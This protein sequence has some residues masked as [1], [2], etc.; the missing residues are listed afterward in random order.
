MSLAYKQPAQYKRSAALF[1]AARSIIPGGVNSTA[2]AIWSGWE[3]YPLFVEKGDGAYLTD[4]D[5][6]T[7]IDYLLGLGPM[8][9]G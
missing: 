7:Y 9:L 3:P 1:D 6:H 2:R 8:I 4:A 5:G